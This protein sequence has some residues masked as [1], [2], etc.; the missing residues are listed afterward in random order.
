MYFIV[1]MRRNKRNLHEAD[2][3]NDAKKKNSSH[4]LSDFSIPCSLPILFLFSQSYFLFVE[5]LFLDLGCLSNDEGTAFI[6]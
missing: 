3:F 6:T 5:F 1:R 4:C 2:K